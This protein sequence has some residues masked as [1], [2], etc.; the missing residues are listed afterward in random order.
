MANEHT[1]EMQTEHTMQLDSI[2]DRLSN[3]EVE[4]YGKSG[5]D[6]GM[7][8][9]V[10]RMDERQKQT[11]RILTAVGV[12]LISGMVTIIVLLLTRGVK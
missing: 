1:L 5:E 7:K 12:A 11:N 2:C 10:I 9:R 6:A 4:L 3:V 8:N